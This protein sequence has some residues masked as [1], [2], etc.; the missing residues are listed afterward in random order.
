MISPGIPRPSRSTAASCRST[1]GRSA[2]TTPTSR[3]DLNNLAVLLQATNRAAGGRAAPPPRPGDR[4]AVATA[5]A[6]PTSRPDLNNLAM[7]LQATNRPR[8]PSRSIAA[9]WRS[10]SGRYGPDHPD[11]AKGLNN[12]AML[13]EATNR[14]AG[15]RAA[16]SAAPWRSTSGRYG[17]DHPDVASDL[18]NLAELLRATNRA[19]GGRAALSPRP[20]DRRAVATAPTTPTSPGTSTTWRSCSGPRTALPEAEPLLPPRPGDRRAVA[21]APTT[22]TSRPDLNN[23][24]GLL[25]ST[26]RAAGGR[27]ALSPRPGDRRAVARPRPPRRRAPTSTT[28]RSCS[29]PRT[30]PPEAEPLMAR[31]VGILSRFQRST[32]HDHPNFGSALGNYRQVAAR[33]EACRA[34]SSP[35]RSSRRLR[36]R[37]SYRPS[38]PRWSG[39][40]ARPD[41]SLTCWP[42]LDR[43]YKEQ[44]KP[45]VYFL[46]PNEPI[47]P[48]LDGLL[49]PNGDGLVAQG[50]TASRTGARADAV[51]LY[52]TALG[53]MAD[54]PAQAPAKLRTR[55]NHAAALAR[56][57][58]VR[59]GA[60]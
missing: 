32:G 37:T 50:V 55:M 7:L 25:A 4:R 53:L 48:H 19:A 52:E 35:H 41:R 44:N 47:V 54:Q 60:R 1:S 42:R 18:N 21:T 9:R 5:P 12:L 46:K 17:P 51:V 22:P 26:N 33:A 45:A 30:A 20:G 16:L 6:T 31:A 38:S 57:R 15:G 28:W 29:G 10:T 23:L 24:A 36:G 58:P 2:P 3:V 39:S 49:Q 43:Q 27:A 13:L 59:A 34:Q 11:V 14:A 8:R 40:S 56:G